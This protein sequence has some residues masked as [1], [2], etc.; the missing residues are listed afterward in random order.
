MVLVGDQLRP[1]TAS[2]QLSP[3]T[4]DSTSAAIGGKH[5]Q[6][7]LAFRPI[8]L[9]EDDCI[10]VRRPCRIELPCGVSSVRRVAIPVA[11]SI[12]QISN[13]RFDRLS[14]SSATPPVG[15]RPGSNRDS[16]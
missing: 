15:V 11:S 4:N 5:G 14:R 8:G 6:A 7:E 10:S 2:A 9:V 13:S 16:C 1:A 3:G 12:V